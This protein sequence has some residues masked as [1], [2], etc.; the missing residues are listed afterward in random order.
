MY[1][2]VC[3]NVFMYVHVFLYW[4][5]VCVYFVCMYVFMYVCI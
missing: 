1:M 4:L 2:Y 3:M 5:Y